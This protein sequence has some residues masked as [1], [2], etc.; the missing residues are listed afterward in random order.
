[1][2]SL[3]FRAVPH[4]AATSPGDDEKE[5]TADYADYTDYT[6]FFFFSSLHASPC[7]RGLFSSQPKVLKS[8]V[9]KLKSGIF[10]FPQPFLPSLVYFTLNIRYGFERIWVYSILG[11]SNFCF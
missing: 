3:A 4:D 10:F 7:L 1:M 5:G 2:N 9:M 8:K 6:D 11:Q